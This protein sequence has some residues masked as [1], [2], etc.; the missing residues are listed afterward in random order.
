MSERADTGEHRRGAALWTPG[1]VARLLDVSPVT[2]RSWDARYGLGPAVR[3]PGAQRRYSDLDIQRLQ[4]MQNLVRDGARPREA[5]AQAKMAL[6]PEPV[7]TTPRHRRHE[8][9]RA[10]E[11][12]HLGRLSELIDATIAAH[13]IVPAW[14]TVLAP[15]LRSVAADSRKA[16]DCVESEW[17]LA[18]AIDAAIDRH[19]RVLPTP[20]GPPVVLGCCRTERHSLPLAALFAALRENRIPSVYLG[21]MVPRRTILGSTGKL[22]APVVVLHSM[23]AGTA[24][25]ELVTELLATVTPPRL[26]L[27]GPGW[28]DTPLPSKRV[29][30]LR[31]LETGLRRVGAL[32][33]H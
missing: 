30:R 16:D 10:A 12:L 6:L 5:A 31:G 8:L 14:R 27:A 24:D 3:R 1:A 11:E 33:T 21:G 17:T 20:A 28:R 18:R 29:S 9:R 13:G 25:T 26:F 15:V 22:S 2:L 23:T 7:G 4:T 32:M 19:V